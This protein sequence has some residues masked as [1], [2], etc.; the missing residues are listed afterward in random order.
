MDEWMKT[1]KATSNGVGVI[2]S[3][4]LLSI[5]PLS[6][7]MDR[8]VEEYPYCSEWMGYNE[9]QS[10]ESILMVVNWKK[11]DVQVIRVQPSLYSV[12][13]NLICLRRY[14]KGYPS[15]YSGQYL[16]QENF[17][18]IFFESNFTIL[19]WGALQFMIIMMIIIIVE[20]RSILTTPVIM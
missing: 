3:R 18:F 16:C 17:V 4:R 19:L 2:R 8:K 12:I 11:D 7:K 10:K 6:M 13:W 9:W 14:S 20:H 15:A 5:M 1:V